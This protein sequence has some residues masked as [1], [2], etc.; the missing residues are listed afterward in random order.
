MNASTAVDV[1]SMAD[2]DDGDDPSLVVDP[3]DD[4]VGS[5]PCAEPVVQRR[6]QLLPHPARLLQQ[7]PGD[8]LVGSRG[9]G[10]RQ[11]YGGLATLMIFTSLI[12]AAGQW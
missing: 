10:F 11:R 9:D 5:A 1:T 6:E 12:D 7:R 3:V 8:E 4:A 2:V